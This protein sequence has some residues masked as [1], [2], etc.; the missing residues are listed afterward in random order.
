MKSYSITSIDSTQYLAD[1]F[2]RYEKIVWLGSLSFEERC[3]GSLIELDENMLKID[4]GFALNYSTTLSPILE[5]QVQRKKNWQYFESLDNK[6]F[7]QH[8]KQYPISSHSFQELQQ[9]LDGILLE[10]KANLFLFDV[11]CM[12]K[13]H[14]IALA[15]YL[16]NAE[17]DFNWVVGYTIPENYPNLDISSKAPGWKDI[18]IAPLAETAWLFYESHSRGIVLPGHES[19]RLVVALA[20]LEP[21][22]GLIMIADTPRRP[23]LRLLSERNNKK[24]I[25]Q[26]TSMR[27][28]NWLTEILSLEDFDLLASRVAS[29]IKMA[30]KFDAPVIL[31]PFGP[32]SLI[33]SAAYHLCC[34]YPEASWFVY[35]IPSSYDVTY[36]EGIQKTYWLSPHGSPN[37]ELTGQGALSF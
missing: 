1:V 10:T 20:E 37:I 24:I 16:A 12:S 27:S 21:S 35:P 31:F 17:S 9:C 6:V 26:L 3:K 25:R 30:H 5:D 13:I 22:G 36:S 32:K 33:F 2:A 14:T 7:A 15:A 4:M 34:E 19:N 23:D 29:E 18:I 11:T 28:R 8:I